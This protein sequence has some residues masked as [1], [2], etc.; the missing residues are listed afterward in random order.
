[1]F[2][3]AVPAFFLSLFG[4]LPTIATAG[5]PVCF[6]YSGRP[7]DM[8]AVQLPSGGALVAARTGLFR[9]DAS[10]LADDVYTRR[11]RRPF[12]RIPISGPDTGDIKEIRPQGDGWLVI[13]SKGQF[14]L[15]RNAAVLTPLVNRD[16][17]AAASDQQNALDD[18]GVFASERA[19]ILRSLESLA[20]GVSSTGVEINLFSEVI[21]GAS[22]GRIN[23][24]RPLKQGGWLVAATGGLLSIDA[25]LRRAYALAGPDPGVV[26]KIASIDSDS[27]VVAASRGL[28]RVDHKGEAA[29]PILKGEVGNS[30][31]LERLANGAWIIGS[32]QPPGL[33]VASPDLR[34]VDPIAGLTGTPLGLVPLREG[35]WL[36]N[37]SKAIARL[38]AT[39]RLIGV[40]AKPKET[41]P[42]SEP[43]FDVL[44]RDDKSFVMVI[45]GDLF[46]IDAGLKRIA[47]VPSPAVRGMIELREQSDGRVSIVTVD[48]M[49]ESIESF[50]DAQVAIQDPERLRGRRPDKTSFVPTTWTLKH[51]C[52]YAIQDS[53]AV[54]LRHDGKTDERNF[55]RVVLLKQT[56]KPAKILKQEDHEDQEDQEEEEQ[57]Q[58]T[59]PGLKFSAN[60]QFPNSG[61]WV[62]QLVSNSKNG[63]VE[64]G[65]PIRVQVYESLSDWARSQ[66]EILLV[67]G[68]ALHSAAF[69]LLFIGAHWSERAFRILNDPVWSTI[70]LWPNFVLRHWN[71]AQRWILA[72]W[73]SNSRRSLRDAG[74]YFDLVI[75]GPN[76]EPME[77]SALLERLRVAPRLW[78]QGRAGMGKSATFQAWERAYY[79]GHSSLHSAVRSFGFILVTIQVRQ[80]AN[81]PFDATQP[82]VWL[83]QAVAHRFRQGGF[84]FSDT[85]LV[86]ALLKSG[87]L[88]IALDGLNEADRDQAVLF[89]ARVFPQTRI[90]ATSQNNPS[91]E[92]QLWR[93]PN[94]I[95]D[96]AEALL[97]LWLGD[98]RA[99]DLLE[100]LLNTGLLS[101]LQS[102]YDL[103]L[104]ADL[105]REDPQNAPLPQSRIDLYRAVLARADLQSSGAFDRL[106]KIAWSIFVEGRRDIGADEIKAMGH[107]VFED[108]EKD[109]VRIVRPVGSGYEFRHD[110]MRAFLAALYL[111][112]D[113]PNAKALASRLTDSPVWRCTRRDQEELWQF[114]SE[115]LSLSA[116]IELIW[117]FTLSTPE[118]AFLQTALFLRAKALGFSLTTSIDTSV[119]A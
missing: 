59:K 41:E 91:F 24:A 8:I 21:V 33:F 45:A 67:I 6:S 90:L 109:G 2:Y 49:L 97:Q 37:F 55:V 20:A 15:D 23:D 50:S 92:F 104:I 107:V 117:Q 52:A 62:L 78:L 68:I 84:D 39:A 36:V 11:Y 34:Q 112:E 30:P 16:Q 28:F 102:G 53:L 65:R 4:L 58:D 56:K 99:N 5:T 46:L 106:K 32:S 86:V 26:Y 18:L 43:S 73:F 108:M 85:S 114:F 3:R 74:P 13:G 7:N 76:D 12:V 101:E 1:M 60:V 44:E 40:I 42:Y 116:E 48:G 27:W 110:Q 10:P 35:G 38:D 61:S 31:L 115:M 80:V 70:G 94:H 75:E 98:K 100:R 17:S 119:L 54:E 96:N 105:A 87:Q 111:I 19:A 14:E 57:E 82:D 77:A 113:S 64:V 29:L 69:I 51:P 103:R 93:L 25:R 72:P 83:I 63:V 79:L 9:L 47:Q 95:S 22:I 71:P 118:R 66:W 89:F 81:L 88:A